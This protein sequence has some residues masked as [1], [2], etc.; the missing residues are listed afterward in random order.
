MSEPVDRLVTICALISRHKMVSRS[1]VLWLTGQVSELRTRVQN[2][3]EANDELV[4]QIN[5]LQAERAADAEA[6]E[7]V[8]VYERALGLDPDEAE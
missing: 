1:D 8:S 5:A 6:A 4:S 3:E 2:V 7:V